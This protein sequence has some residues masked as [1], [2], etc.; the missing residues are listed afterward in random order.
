MTE[1]ENLFRQ[2]RWIV[3]MVEGERVVR[4][5]G[6]K[7]R[8]KDVVSACENI[9]KPVIHVRPDLSKTQ[10]A[11]QTALANPQAS[12]HEIS[13]TLGLDVGGVSRAA[14]AVLKPCPTCGHCSR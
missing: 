6:E 4:P 2:H 11:V 7:S 14:K 12:L 3:A 8:F 13:R 1:I 5:V 9:A 10:L